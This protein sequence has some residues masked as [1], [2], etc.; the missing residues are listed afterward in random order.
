MRRIT[1]VVRPGKGARILAVSSLL[2]A[3]LML[4]GCSAVNLTG[5][6][7]PSF[8]LTNKSADDVTGSIG[9]GEQDLQE[10]SE[11]KLGAQ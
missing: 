9:Q 2:S 11:E 1:R 4:S 7:F 8:G 6:D 5:F 10:Q 3:A